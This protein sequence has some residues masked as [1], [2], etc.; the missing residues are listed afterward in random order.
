[1]DGN[2]KPKNTPANTAVMPSGKPLFVSIVHGNS[3]SNGEASSS[4]KFRAISLND[5]DLISVED[6][7]RVLLVKLKEVDSMSNMYKICHNEGF[8]D[9]KIHHAVDKRLIWVEINGLPLCA[10]GSNAFKK[11][12]C[13]FGRFMFFEAEET[14]VMCT[15]LGTWSINIVDE[16]LRSSSTDD[17]NVVKKAVDIDDNNFMDDLENTLE[18]L[19]DDNLDKGAD[20]PFNSDSCNSVNDSI[21]DLENTIEE[22]ADDN[23]DKGADTPFNSNSCNLVNDH[24]PPGFEHLK[25]GSSSTRKCST[26][27]GRYHKKD[28]KGISLIHELTR[29]IEVRSSFGLDVRGCLRK[30]NERFGLIF[31]QTEADT[32]NSFIVS[33]GLIEVQ[34]GRRL[35]TWMNKAGTKLSKLDRF[36]ITEDI[37]EALL[38]VH[39]FHSLFLRDGFD[40]TITLEWANLGQN[41]NGRKILSHEKL[42]LLKPRIKQ[43]HSLTKS[44]ERTQKQEGIVVVKNIEE[45][46]E[47]GVASSDDRETRLKL[48]HELDKLENLE[49]LDTIQK[50]RI[51]WDMDGNENTKCFH[52]LVNKKR[53]TQS[54]HADDSMAVFP[55]LINAPALHP[56]I[57]DSLE[58]GVS[59]DEVRKAVWDCGGEKAP[60]PDGKMPIGSNSSFFTLIPKV[61]NPIFIKDFRPISLISI[62]YKIVAKILVNRLSKVI[63]NIVTHEQ[64]AFISGSE[65]LD[66]PLML[67]EVIDWYKKWKKKMLNFKVNFEKAFDSVSWKYLDFVLHSIGF[68]L[69]WRSW[70]KAFLQSSRALVLVNGSPTSEFSLKRGLRQGDPLSPFLFILVMEGLHVAL[71]NAVSSGL[72]RGVKFG[73]PKMNLS[74][75][76]YADDVVITTE[77]S[78]HDMDNIIRVLRVSDMA[79]NMGCASG[80]FPFTYL[81]LP[82]CSNMN[83]TSNWKCLVDRFHSKLSNWNA[84][85]LSFGGRLTLIKVVLGSLRIY[86]LSIFKAP[87]LILNSLERIR[88]NFFWGGAIVSKKIAWVK[89]SNVLS[90]F[91]KGGLGVGSLKSFNFSLLKKWRWRLYSN[92]HALWVKILKSLHG[93]EGGFDQVGC[94]TNGISAKIVGS[95]N[96]LHSNG[97]L[98]VDSLRYKVGCGSLIRLW[99]DTWLG[100]SPLYLR[101][102]ILFRLEQDKDCLI[103][104][105]FSNGQWHWN[106]SRVVLGIRNS[107]YLRDSLNE[108][109]QINIGSYCDTCVW[110]LTTMVSF[111]WRLKLDR[112][113]HR[114]NLSSRG[115]EIPVISCSTCNGNVESTQHIFFECAFAK[116][117]WRLVCIWCDPL[118]PPFMCNDHWRDWLSS[119][120]ISKEKNHRGDPAAPSLGTCYDFTP[121]TSALLRH[122]LCGKVTD[123]GHVLPFPF[124]Y[125]CT[126]GGTRPLG[127]GIQRLAHPRGIATLCPG[128]CSKFLSRPGQLSGIDD[129]TSFSSP[130]S[131]ITDTLVSFF[132]LHPIKP[133][134]HACAW[135]PVYSFDVSFCDRTPQAGILN[136]LGYSTARSAF[137]LGFLS[138]LYAISRLT[139]NSLMPLRIQLGSFHSLSSSRD[140]GFDGGLK[141]PH[142]DVYAHLFPD[143]A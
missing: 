134:I 118:I 10:W 13:M 113:P 141:K 131:A 71:S 94:K 132:A 47:A 6:S 57:R 70:I 14:A 68:G 51:K 142:T 60:G 116:D 4:K 12:A 120:P 87:A 117:I 67:S 76:Y 58:L 17:V 95:S 101:F 93:Y 26:S 79:S 54:I 16:S 1:M 108:I 7:S 125:V 41:D 124:H 15:E 111:P 81:G 66:G 123:S 127:K 33:V 86:L 9:L 28:V 105:H 36:L 126:G 138:D 104:D 107:T 133:R 91:D 40:D 110:S 135:A 115:I 32:F 103:I 112:L 48:L 80:L 139:G 61:S 50:S 129:L 20:T 42:R 92:P 122:P 19:V 22:L 46:I 3:K 96:Y 34:M 35:F 72:I 25:K 30:E 143:N 73:F 90:S 130:S 136:A 49:A 84:N 44:K 98:P 114:L 11:V 137:A 52:G 78:S 106:W 65:I 89:W 29:L 5:S 31:S 140:P 97:I 100:N 45:K 53:R 43:W 99:K 8:V 109:D 37:I 74:H 82:I 24:C 63:D 56:S 77:W 85:Y 55:P 39:L 119:W 128:H 121:V 27:F 21:D 59:L 18:E 62:H 102:N 64:S 23:L 88:A 83:L 75:L 2:R 69:K 38:D